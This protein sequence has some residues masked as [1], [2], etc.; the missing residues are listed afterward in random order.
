MIHDKYILNENGEPVVEPDL[1]KWAKWVESNHPL[2]IVKQERVGNLEVSTVFLYLNH[3]FGPGN[4]IL[5]E[6]M[7]FKRVKGKR[8]KP[9]DQFRCGGSR[10]QAEAMHERAKQR[11][12]CRQSRNGITHEP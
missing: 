7:I 5:W 9:V 2:Q 1:L 3:R 11:V 12:L 8:V 4:P 10:E 6:T